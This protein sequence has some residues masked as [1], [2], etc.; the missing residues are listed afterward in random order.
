LYDEILFF[1]FKSWTET[2]ECVATFIPGAPSMHR[3]RGEACGFGKY[4][5]ENPLGGQQ[6]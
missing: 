2:G 5:T 4:Q 1:R 3:H 6:V